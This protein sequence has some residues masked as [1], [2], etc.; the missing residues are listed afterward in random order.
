MRKIYFVLIFGF[1]LLV[2]G[3]IALENIKATLLEDFTS[4]LVLIQDE[5]VPAQQ[6]YLSSFFMEKGANQTLGIMNSNPQILIGVQV[7]NPE[8]DLIEN[9]SF[10][11]KI[12]VTIQPEIEGVYE[13]A[14]TNFGQLG[15]TISAIITTDPIIETMNQFIELTIQTIASIASIAIG[16]IVLIIGGIFLIYNWKKIRNNKISQKK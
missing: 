8:G 5:S 16:I 13:L 6:A 9:T 11:D 4:T 15:V 3:N 14:I 7:R 1:V 10:Y 2:G 12:A